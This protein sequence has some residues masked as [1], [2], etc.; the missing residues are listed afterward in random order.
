MPA[1][2]N[3]KMRVLLGK[4]LGDDVAR[5]EPFI[6]GAVDEITLEAFT[7][8]EWE[9]TVLRWKAEYDQA[10]YSYDWREVWLTVSEE[11]L[12]QVY[13]PKPIPAEIET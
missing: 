5:Y 13:D 3:R 7:A 10:H 9:R 12:K 2:K 1:K 8:G 6:A 4:V 11:R